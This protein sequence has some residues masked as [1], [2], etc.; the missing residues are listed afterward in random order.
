[1][2]DNDPFGYVAFRRD[3]KKRF[4][5]FLLTFDEE[6]LK[7]WK[8]KDVNVEAGKDTDLQPKTTPEKDNASTEEQSGPEELLERF[9]QSMSSFSG[10]YSDNKCNCAMTIGMFIEHSLLSHAEKNLRLIEQDEDTSVF[11]F[12]RSQ[13]SDLKN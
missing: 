6:S 7:K 3:D 4:G 11:D 10:D 1:M 9:L 5:S 8:S 2:G 12:K 13:F